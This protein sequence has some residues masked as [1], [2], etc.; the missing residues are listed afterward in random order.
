MPFL[1]RLPLTAEFRAGARAG[2]RAFLPQSIGLIPWGMVTGVAMV[3]SGLTPIEAMGMNVLVFSGTAQLG[4]LPLIAAGAPLWLIIAT[5]LALNL[6]FLIFSAGIA[7]NFQQLRMPARW[8]VGYLLVDGVFAICL[9]P[10]RRN[11]DPQWRL[12]HYL[13]PSLWAWA[14]WQLCALTGI[15]FAGAIPGSWSLEFMATIALLALLLPMAGTRPMLVAALTG[16]A[17]A[18]ALHGLP[19]R[20]GLLV[21]MVAGILSGFAAER[22]HSP[23]AGS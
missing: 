21:A 6:R 8:G 4:T 2:F 22:Q 16:G 14:V 23:V 5:A 11:P 13:A 10:M 15:L 1:N 3:G 17:V 18:V 7:G 19:L 9:E 12:G 20:L